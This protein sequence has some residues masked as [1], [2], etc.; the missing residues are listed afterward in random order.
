M[1]V[2]KKDSASALKI[3]RI[4]SWLSA[5]GVEI[6][7]RY[8]G[9]IITIGDQSFVM[10][11]DATKELVQSFPPYGEPNVIQTLEDHINGN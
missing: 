2:L 1:L 3:E 9:M 8:D 5:E 10:K 11:D 7:S 6:S 4:M